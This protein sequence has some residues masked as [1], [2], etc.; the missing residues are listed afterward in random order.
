MTA[1]ELMLKTNHYLIKGGKLNDIQQAN[2][3]GQLLS[4]RSDERSIESFK[5]GVKAPEYMVSIRQSNDNRIM[6]PLF[7]IPLY[8][9]GKKLKTVFQ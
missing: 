2:I 9:D 5:K 4:A 8:N 6:Y 7:Y 3:V 1:Y